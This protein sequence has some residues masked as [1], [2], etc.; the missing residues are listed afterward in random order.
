[1]VKCYYIYGGYYIY[2]CYYIYGWYTC[3]LVAMLP[4]TCYPRKQGARDRRRC[5]MG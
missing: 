4:V 3:A 5:F 1:M 2:G